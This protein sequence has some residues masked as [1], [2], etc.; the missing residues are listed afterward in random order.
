MPHLFGVNVFFKTHKHSRAKAMVEDL[1]EVLDQLF[2][3][4]ATGIPSRGRG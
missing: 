1:N 2:K 4:F 3:Q